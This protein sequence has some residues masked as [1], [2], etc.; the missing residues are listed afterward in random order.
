MAAQQTYSFTRI[1][2]DQ[3]WVRRWQVRKNASDTTYV[4]AMQSDGQWGC[5][6]PAWKFGR[7]IPNSTVRA[8]CKHISMIKQF[9]P[10]SYINEGLNKPVANQVPF[11]PKV[12]KPVIP[13]SEPK[14]K[15]THV[16]CNFCDTMVP[17]EK[18]TKYKGDPI[19]D[20]CLQYEL[21]AKIELEEAKKRVKD[22]EAA[23]FR[24]QMQPSQSTDTSLLQ[25]KKRIIHIR[26]KE[27]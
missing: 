5:S 16:Q 6:C 15:Q 21:Q 2:A 19:C 8:D 26:K 27:D 14:H 3:R 9:E 22:M 11:L 23:E 24:Q 17:A 12:P 25:P 7:T 4:V 13:F 18:H 20:V 1:T 10:M